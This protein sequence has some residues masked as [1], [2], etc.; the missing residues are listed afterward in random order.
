MRHINNM[1]EFLES[2]EE[3]KQ[4]NDYN[5]LMIYL[6]VDNW[7]KVQEVI[8]E[9]ELYIDPNDTSYGREDEPHVTLI[10]MAFMIFQIVILKMISRILNALKLNSREYLTSQVIILMF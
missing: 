4:V 1:K 8:S 10:Y 5:C 9:D 2:K 6:D 3:K 7:D